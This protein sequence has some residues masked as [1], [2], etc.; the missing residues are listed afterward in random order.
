MN[1]LPWNWRLPLEMDGWKMKTFLMFPL[2][3]GLFSEAMLFTGRIPTNLLRVPQPL[4]DFPLLF[5][6]H[7]RASIAIT[8]GRTTIAVQFHLDWS[9]SRQYLRGDPPARWAG[10]D[11]KMLRF[12]LDCLPNSAGKEWK[13]YDTCMR[14]TLL[15]QCT[16]CILEWSNMCKLCLWNRAY[17]ELLKIDQNGRRGIAYLFFKH[18][19][20]GWALI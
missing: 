19:K 13:R 7:R 12:V 18:M 20:I 3:S 14:Y 1:T 2:G 15:S 5:F 8:N 9:R 17:R 4:P 16:S 6:F 11:W 10:N